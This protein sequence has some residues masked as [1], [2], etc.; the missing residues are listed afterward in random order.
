MKARYK[1][2]SLEFKTPGGTSRGVLRQK[3]TW[4]LILEGN[5]N[6]GIG[7]CA[8]FRGLSADDVPGYEEKL[9]WL[10]KHIE[11]DP[12]SLY[13]QL[14]GYPSIQ[15]GLEQ[16]LRSLAISDDFTLFP[17][18][19]TSGK[20]GIEINGLVWMGAVT[21]MRSEVRKKIHNGFVCIKI[22]IGALDFTE[23]MNFLEEVREMGGPDLEI[24]VDAN[25][26][27]SPDN[28][29]DKLKALASLNI[30]SIEQPI[31]AGQPEAMQRLCKESPIPVAL[32][33]E[34]IGIFK[35]NEKINLLE[36][37]APPYIILKPSLLGG[38]RHCEEWMEIA[39]R[40]RIRYW[41]TS[42]LESNI[43]LNA[44][45][46]WAADLGITMPQGLGTGGLFTNNF[47]SPLH[48]EGSYLRYD[49]DMSWD[50]QTLT[51]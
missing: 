33:E 46:Q 43:G 50:I 2:Y 14:E 31:R 44:I 51:T 15:F 24:R 37:I 6:R 17:S 32:D 16:A 25:G 47:T 41:V 42:A 19:F 40:H 9:N 38:F 49:P 22:K 18:D 5:G 11:E 35:S 20:K 29:L 36:R 7:E 34:L 10:C 39:S 1:K 8:M 23:E 45:A 13:E 27:F 3:D 28:A 12:T 4:F 21:Q 48:V 30:H 26:A